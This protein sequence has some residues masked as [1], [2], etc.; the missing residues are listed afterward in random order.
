MKTAEEM[1]KMT[2]K[3]NVF[4]EWCETKLAK[5]IEDAANKGEYQLELEVDSIKEFSQFS[6]PA[7]CSN[8]KKYLDQFG[9]RTISYSNNKKIEISWE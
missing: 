9:Y 1:R 4:A 2:V 7:I 3:N 6:R 8:L 5:A